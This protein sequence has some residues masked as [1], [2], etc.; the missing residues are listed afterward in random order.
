MALTPFPLWSEQNHYLNNKINILE[1]EIVELENHVM[2]I[3]AI[4]ES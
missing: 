1:Q 3:D 4:A 2:R